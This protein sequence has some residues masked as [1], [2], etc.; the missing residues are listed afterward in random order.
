MERSGRKLGGLSEKSERRKAL[1]G[2]YNIHY[3]AGHFFCEILFQALQRTRPRLYAP[4]YLRS[5]LC[6]FLYFWLRA[7]APCSLCSPHSFP[8]SNRLSWKI[9][10]NLFLFRNY[11]ENNQFQ[12]CLRAVTPKEL[13]DI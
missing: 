1:K 2:L 4:S 10:G 8:S 3:R 6:S 9:F 13:Y 11:N 7:K 12:S 5:R